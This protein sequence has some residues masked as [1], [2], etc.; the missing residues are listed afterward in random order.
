MRKA[1]SRGAPFF[2]VVIPIY[3]RAGELRTAIESVRAQTFQDFEIIVVDDGSRDDPEAVVGAFRDP[4][5]HVIHQRNAG[6]GAARN[7]G[8]DAVRGPF[9]AFLDSDDVYL[10]H[11]LG[12]MHTLLKD[13]RDI[14]G[15]A[16]VWVDR[17]QGPV[18]LKPPRAIR[19]AEDMA[20]YLLCDRGFTQTSTMV[21]PREAAQK[22]RFNEHLRAAEDTDF[23]IR[24]HL[25]GCRF[26][27][28][29]KAGAIWNDRD[30]PA[31][32]SADACIEQPRAWLEEMK[33]LIHPKAYHGARGW[34]YAKRVAQTRP[35]MAL[36]LYLNAV[37]RGCYRPSLAGVI[38]LQI[39]LGT[40]L[41]RRVADHLIATLPVGLRQLR[42]PRRAGCSAI[43]AD[44]A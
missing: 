34:P 43:S 2:T 14:A 19:L 35:L 37:V 12:S 30:D 44:G 6:G 27:M 39:F 33:P 4:Q 24:L 5:L 18:F 13:T 10:P 16:R 32:A 3:N 23:A 41:Y 25:A 21:V 38:F 1:A 29:E 40:G 28:L 22:I 20:I 9:V 26:R 7:R 42:A 11:H 8:I 17:G 31:R 15:Y 36:G